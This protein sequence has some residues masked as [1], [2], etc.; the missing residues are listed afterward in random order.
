MRSQRSAISLGVYEEL[1]GEIYEA[2]QALRGKD[3]QNSLLEMVSVTDV[4]ITASSA[5]D[6]RYKVEQEGQEGITRETA[7][8][9]YVKDLRDS[10]RIFA[11]EERQEGVTRETATELS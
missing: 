8:R 1:A 2:Q 6:K 4:D 7:L 3:K 10:S 5:F 11:I 9:Q